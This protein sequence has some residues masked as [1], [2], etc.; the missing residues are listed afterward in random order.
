VADGDGRVELQRVADRHEVGGVLVDGA[1]LP[2]GDAAA[3]TAA[4]E[5]ERGDPDAVEVEAFDERVP[6]R[7]VVLEPVHQDEVQPLPAGDGDLGVA[8]V[9]FTP[10][11]A[12]RVDDG[13]AWPTARRP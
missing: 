13:R 1:P 2:R 9:R 8:D 7:V 6:G 4:D 12:P 10:R 5:V 11:S 3:A